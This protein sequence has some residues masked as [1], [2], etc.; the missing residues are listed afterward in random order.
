M[1]TS[2][3]PGII[4]FLALLA[5][6]LYLIATYS[7]LPQQVATH[8]NASGQPNGWMSRREAVLFQGIL[9]ILLPVFITGLFYAIRFLP[10]NYI[11]VP[12]RDYWFSPQ[13]RN[14]TLSYFLEKGY[15]LAILLTGLM[16]LVWYHIIE[17]NT[18][19]NR[20]FS[21]FHF[22]EWMGVFIL[23]MSWWIISFMRHFYV[24]ESIQN[25]VQ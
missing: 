17:V 15:W 23:C 24:K 5:Y 19:P 25:T 3:I 11:N 7:M 22:L 20:L 1:K 18:H 12:N 6:L 9:G 10:L 2:R 16:G 13:R 4:L 8:F 14:D 21:P